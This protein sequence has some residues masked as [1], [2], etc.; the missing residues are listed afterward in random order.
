M[1]NDFLK[2]SKI[3]G[4]SRMLKKSVQWTASGSWQRAVPG[5]AVRHRLPPG[6]REESAAVNPCR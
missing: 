4:T 3:K 2:K 1:T 5:S 6:T